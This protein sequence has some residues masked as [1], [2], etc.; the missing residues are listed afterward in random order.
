MRETKSWLVLDSILP[1]GLIRA[2]Y[3][4]TGMLYTHRDSE[5]L[6]TN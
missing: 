2:C 6:Q 5:L 4:A 1:I 3:I